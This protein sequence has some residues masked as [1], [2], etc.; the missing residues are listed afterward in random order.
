MAKPGKKV[1]RKFV[2]REEDLWSLDMWLADVISKSVHEF[3]KGGVG[4]YPAML[5]PDPGDSPY[6][7]DAEKEWER[8]LK[9][10]DVGF[11]IGAKDLFPSGADEAKWKEGFDLFVKYF[12]H[13]WT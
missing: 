10:I 11:A 12:G 2:L 4:G 5:D 9:A 6:S 3:R 13:L 8:I 1:V 7:K